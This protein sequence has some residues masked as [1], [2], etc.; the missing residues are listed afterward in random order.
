MA[1]NADQF[2]D[3]ELSKEDREQI[4]EDPH[5]GAQSHTPQNG[6]RWVFNQ[7]I[8]ILK[9]YF[10]YFFLPARTT[11][12]A[13]NVP[14]PYSN[15]YFFFFNTQPYLKFSFCDSFFFLFFKFYSPNSLPFLS[16]RIIHV[17]FFFL[18]FWTFFYSIVLRAKYHFLYFVVVN[19]GFSNLNIL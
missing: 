16:S 7:Q 3:L 8:F 4:F 2:A 12:Y 6:S 19:R 11:S 15:F 17:I 18:I 10:V 9:L 5:E 13:S 14:Y 1:S